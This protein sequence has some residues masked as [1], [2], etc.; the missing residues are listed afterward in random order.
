MT[1]NRKHHLGTLALH[2]GQQ[3]DFLERQQLRGDQSKR[4]RNVAL[5]LEDRGTE[6]ARLAELETE[7]RA[8]LLLQ[9]L[10]AAV[11]GDGLHQFDG[12]LRLEDFGLERPK[13]TVQP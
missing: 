3:A 6:S 9:F 1:E 12:V 10:L 5:L 4:D 11:G 7:V 2:A 13:A 8:A